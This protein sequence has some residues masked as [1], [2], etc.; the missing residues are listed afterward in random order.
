MQWLVLGS[1]VTTGRFDF[2]ASLKSMLKQI[3]LPSI[4]L[5]TLCSASPI[6][7]CLSRYNETEFILRRIL[8][9]HRKVGFLF[10]IMFII[11]FSTLLFTYRTLLGEIGI[12]TRSRTVISHVGNS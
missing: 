5:E 7:P 12:W 9:A 3:H 8:F 6:T 4:D 2:S 10:T 1:S 11:L